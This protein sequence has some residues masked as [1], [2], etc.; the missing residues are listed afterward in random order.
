MPESSFVMAPSVEAKDR[1]LNPA[2]PD[3]ASVAS[4]RTLMPVRFNLGHHATVHR[5]VLLEDT[6]WYMNVS[7]NELTERADNGAYNCC[8]T[9]RDN[10]RLK[11]AWHGR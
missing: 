4:I 8:K 5:A 7:M 3:C 6:A 2:Y 1:H 10:I 11:D 9:L